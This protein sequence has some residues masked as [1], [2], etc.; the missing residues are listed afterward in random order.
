MIKS[1]CCIGSFSPVSYTHLDVYKRQLLRGLGLSHS[2]ISVMT[3]L[4]SVTGIFCNWVW[5]RMAN[6]AAVGVMRNQPM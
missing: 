1:V 5:G 2:Y 3:I 6:S 4:A